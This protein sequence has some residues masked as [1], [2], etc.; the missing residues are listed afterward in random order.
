MHVDGNLNSEWHI[1]E[2]VEP[3]AIHFGL[4]AIGQSFICQDVNARPHATHIAQNYHNANRDY[5]HMEWPAYSMDF[6]P[7]EQAWDMLGHA[8]SKVQWRQECVNALLMA[9]SHGEV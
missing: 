8:L 6:N 1:H 9:R 3:V 7:I 2:I 5:T 4:Q